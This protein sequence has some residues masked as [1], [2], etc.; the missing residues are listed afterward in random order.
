MEEKEKHIAALDGVRGIAILLVLL[1]HFIPPIAMPW[2]V[3][4]W[5]MKIFS[6]G[7]W[8]GVDLFFVLSGFLIT[9]ILLRTKDQ[10]HY[11]INFYMRRTLRIFPLYFAAL[12]IIFIIL[13]YFVETPS[14][15]AARENQI[16][17]WTYLANVAVFKFGFDGV[18]SDIVF[19]SAY[20]SLA[21]E[22]RI[23]G[24]VSGDFAGS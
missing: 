11:F 9:G 16:Y 22:V 24:I 15:A 13:P 10:P 18:D 19:P 8:A 17:F 6:T 7:G 20:W 5:F 23:S 14:F 3:S 12:A 21:V 1:V 2:R 4:E